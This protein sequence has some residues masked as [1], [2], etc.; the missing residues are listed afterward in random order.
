MTGVYRDVKREVTASGIGRDL[1]HLGEKRIRQC[2]K[3]HLL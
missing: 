3:K 1:A 2:L